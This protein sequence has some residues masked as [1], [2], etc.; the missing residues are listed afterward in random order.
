A[1][2][3][4]ALRFT[5]EMLRLFGSSDRRGLFETGADAE[6]LPV[7]SRSAYDGVI[8]SGNSVAAMNLLRL[9]RIVGDESMV[10]EGE[11]ILRAFMG[12]VTR[13]PAGYLQFLSA[14]DVFSGPAVEVTLAGP[15]DKDETRRMLLTVKG[16]FIPNLVVMHEVGEGPAVAQVCAKGACRP[17][18][19]TAEELERLLDEV[20]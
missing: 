14:F 11:A 4:D 17:P 16:R 9:G 3:E 10:Q 2:L 12:G 13:Q 19:Q 6:Q 7:R 18:V 8:P 1:Y 5:R 15:L 20:L